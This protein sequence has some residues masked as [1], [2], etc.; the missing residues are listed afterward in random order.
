MW[1]NKTSEMSTER[2]TNLALRK[3]EMKHL[4]DTKL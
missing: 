2:D 1:V 4:A 3:V